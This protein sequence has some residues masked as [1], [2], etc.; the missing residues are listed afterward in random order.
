MNRA[1]KKRGLSVEEKV[2]RVEERFFSHPTPYT[3]KEL[4]VVLPKVTG[5]ILQ[6]IEECLELLVS[7]NRISQKKIGVHVLFWWFPKTAAQQLAA[8]FNASGSG[9][10]VAAAKHMS[11]GYGMGLPQ[12]QKE[13]HALGVQEAEARRR[14]ED[15]CTGIGDAASVRRDSAKMRQLQE[16]VKALR[17][18]LEKLAVFDPVMIERVRA[19]TEVAW[20]AANRW[21]DNMRLL[22][23]HISQRMGLT[24]RE[25]R[26][27]EDVDY[28]EF[29][30]LVREKNDKSKAVPATSEGASS[31]PLR[32]AE[33]GIGGEMGVPPPSPAA[34]ATD[35]SAAPGTRSA[36]ERVK[37][38]RGDGVAAA[39]EGQTG[40]VKRP[41]TEAKKDVVGH[42]AARCGKKKKVLQRCA[43][44]ASGLSYI[45][46]RLQCVQVCVGSVSNRGKRLP[47]GAVLLSLPRGKARMW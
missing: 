13:V 26:L 20:E 23:R 25:L 7:E 22:E 47:A 35:T 15:V 28:I 4:L 40:A 1:P 32:G 9:G 37:R 18:E 30:D 45:T 34:E 29:E 3:L 33:G 17:A 16:E 31:S 43:P 38:G 6:S 5:V 12:L 21:T 24:P 46:P 42:T 36:Q 14:V 2:S 44:R 27:P 11:M 10:A 41:R 8:A 19:T 39:T